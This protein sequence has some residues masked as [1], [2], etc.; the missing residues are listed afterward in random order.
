[1]SSPHRGPVG[2]ATP[3]FLLA[4]QYGHLVP[5]W[6]SKGLLCLCLHCSSDPVTEKKRDCSCYFHNA[7]CA[8][9]ASPGLHRRTDVCV[10]VPIIMSQWGLN[11]LV[12]MGTF[13]VKPKM[14]VLTVRLLFQDLTFGFSVRIR[15]RLGLVLRLSCLFGWEERRTVGFNQWKGSVACRSKKPWDLSYIYPLLLTQCGPKLLT[16][17]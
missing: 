10:R 3:P 8:G 17:P 13:T 7:F 9:K 5:P 4:S 11:A 15:F 1:M 12:S 6:R 2:L 16:Y 14:E